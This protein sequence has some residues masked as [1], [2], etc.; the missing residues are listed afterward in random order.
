M[1]SFLASFCRVSALRRQGAGLVAGMATAMG[2][3]AASPAWAACPSGEGEATQFVQF[4]SPNIATSPVSLLTLKAKLSYPGS[5]DGQK[6]CL[7]NRKL[8]AVVILHG[9][10]GV[11]SRGDFYQAAL[12]AAGI[13]TLQVDMWEARGVAG[14]A[15]RPAA[16]I[17][18]YP[19]AFSALAYLSALP[20]VDGARVGILGFSWGGVISLATSENL[21]AALFGNGKRFAAHVAN[22]PVCYGANNPA[23]PAFQPAAQ[24]GTQYLNL[25]GKPVLIQIGSQDGYDNGSAHCKDLAALVNSRNPG[26]LV[27]VQ[28]YPGAF[29]AWDR[30]MIPVVV[31]E[32]YG[33]EGS[34]F[35]TGVVPKVTIK[36]DVAQ[37]LSSRSL[38]TQFFKRTL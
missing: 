21:Y 25:T 4:P 35:L 19:D 17:L 38:V 3:V 23:I 1:A 26:N 32:P 5:F 33:N 13:V 7:G 12:N 2:L 27:Q 36:P 18:T 15:N 37:A 10:S 34:Y 6:R 28:E 31:D 8:P 29:H 16:P 11:D 9:S 22:Y 30:L 14:L 20:E 24:K